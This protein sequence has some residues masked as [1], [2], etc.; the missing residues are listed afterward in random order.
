VAIGD[1][2]SVWDLARQK[3]SQVV[4]D[5]SHS[6]VWTADGR[7]LLYFCAGLCSKAADGTGAA[8]RL[9]DGL[10]SGVTRDGKQV[11]STE[12]QGPWT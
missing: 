6:P 5:I 7:R 8:E 4:F 2:I 12:S 3:F 10:P 11:R 9:A 1:F